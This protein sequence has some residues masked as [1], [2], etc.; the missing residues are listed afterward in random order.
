MYNEPLR[1]FFDTDEKRFGGFGRLMPRTQHPVT[2]AKDSRPHSVKIYLPS[3][4]CAVYVRD[5][6]Y[7]EKQGMIT[8]TPVREPSEAASPF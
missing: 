2:G 5:S 6:I 3:S 7:N 1:L 4:T 8:A